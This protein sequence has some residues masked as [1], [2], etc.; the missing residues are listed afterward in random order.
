MLNR[1]KFLGFRTADQTFAR[2]YI[3]LNG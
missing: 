3:E 1:N 2:F